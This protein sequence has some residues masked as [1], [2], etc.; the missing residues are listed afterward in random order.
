MSYP[1][2]GAAI[3]A[4]VARPQEPGHYPGV[5]V[6][7][8]AFGPVE[9]IHDVARRFANRGYIAIAPNLYSRVGTPNPSDTQEVFKKMFGLQD[10]QIVRDLEGAASYLRATGYSNGKVGVIGFCSGGRQTLLMASSSHAVDAAVDCW[11]GFIRSATPD[12]A[13][14]PERPTPIIDM[15]EN[16]S[17]PLF[18]VIG[19]E[20]QNPSPEDGELLSK[21]LKQAG[22]DFQLKVYRNAGHAF[23]ADYRPNYREKA[24]FELWDDVSRF[25]D[26]HLKK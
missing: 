7:H 23:F 5:I 17:C 9:H 13:T 24:A 25:F 26:Q 3:E 8:E 20:D 19:E 12:A 21:R 14:T 15:A 10:G 11:G 18:V 4:Y 2:D 1:V 22:K 16:V 6:I